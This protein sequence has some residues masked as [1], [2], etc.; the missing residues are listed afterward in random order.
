MWKTACVTVAVLVLGAISPARAIDFQVGQAWS[1]DARPGEEAS[2]IYV[3]KIDRDLATRTIYHIYVDGLK[4]KNPLI[5]GGVQD[6]LP[7]VPISREALEAS[8]TG[9]PRMLT[10]IPDISEGYVIWRD[11]FVEG[12]A[13]VFT[14]P[15]KQVVQH[16]EDAFN[17]P[18]Q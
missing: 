13:G 10:Q 4:L 9:E 7:H 8:V 2:Q 14:A 16:I 3:A 17:A 12:Q 5:E 1:Y 18:K 11:A 15:V 6:D